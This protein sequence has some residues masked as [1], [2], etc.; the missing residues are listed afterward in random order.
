[1][2]KVIIFGTA[3]FA[4]VVH[5]Y[6]THESEHEVVAF[7]AHQRYITDDNSI[8]CNLPVVPFES[9]EETYPPDEYDMFVAMGYT[10]VNQTRAQIY[11]DAKAKGYTLITYISPHCTFHAKSIGDNCFIF[12]DNTVQPF[13]EIGN[14]VVLWSGNHIGHHSTIDDHTFISSHVVISGLCHIGKYCFLGVN[15]T[16]RDGITIADSNVI[17]AGAIIMKDTKDKEVYIPDRTRVFKRNSEEIN[18]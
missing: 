10:K 16:F 5:Y 6:L 2:S 3:S 12:E 18:F 9:I 13:V 17:G 1:M 11:D 4:E 15:S 7:T 14:N 8:F